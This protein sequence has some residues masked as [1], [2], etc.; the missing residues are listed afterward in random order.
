MAGLSCY[1]GPL[2][3]GA[4][5]CFSEIAVQTSPMH[6][7]AGRA[8]LD[9]L[10]SI[11]DLY[12]VGIPHPAET[13][14]DH[15]RRPSPEQSLQRFLDKRLGNCVHAGCRFIHHQDVQVDEQRTRD[16]D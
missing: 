3:S 9:D 11:D 6:N 1:P 15:G 7:F 2:L 5:H 10:S 13:V 12:A 16:R 14:R 8:V 4:M